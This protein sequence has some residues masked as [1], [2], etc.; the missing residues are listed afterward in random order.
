MQLMGALHRQGPSFDSCL[1]VCLSCSGLTLQRSTRGLPTSCMCMWP[2]PRSA[3]TTGARQ[4][5]SVTISVFA[6]LCPHLV[7]V[8]GIY[9][10]AP[11]VHTYLYASVH[12]AFYQVRTLSVS[13]S[14]NIVCCLA[15]DAVSSGEVPATAHKEEFSVGQMAGRMEIISAHEISM[16]K[17]LGSGG[18]GEVRPEPFYGVLGLALKTTCA[19]AS[20]TVERPPCVVWDSTGLK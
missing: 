5:A 13:R 15:G 18:Y 7:D 4:P 1:P 2:G 17:F 3:V 11:P 10:A 12:H 16:A 9:N 20:L 8:N 14:Q 6:F 19:Y